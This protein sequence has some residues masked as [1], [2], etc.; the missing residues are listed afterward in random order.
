[1]VIGIGIG[2]DMGMPTGR[3]GIERG[4]IMEEEG[5]DDVTG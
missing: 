5:E 3:P 1:M 4:S 2:S